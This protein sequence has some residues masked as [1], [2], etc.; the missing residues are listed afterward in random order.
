MNKWPHEVQH[1]SPGE[2]MICCVQDGF[3]QRFRL[4][5]K[6]R[7]TSEKL[8]MLAE[9]REMHMYINPDK[10]RTLPRRHQVQIDNYINA[11]K[12]GGQLS[13]ELEVR[14]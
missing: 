2:V 6:G 14:K 1:Y 7:A 5:M 9:W 12:R 3:W 11:L 10:S 4:S 8:D 13:M